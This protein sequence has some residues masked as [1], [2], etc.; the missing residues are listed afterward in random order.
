M[1][2]EFKQTERGMEYCVVDVYSLTHKY[3]DRWVLF[4][5]PV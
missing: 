4:L 1:G 2:I 5:A 3:R